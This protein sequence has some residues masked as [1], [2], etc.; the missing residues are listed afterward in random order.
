MAEME[1]ALLFVRINDLEKVGDILQRMDKE[2]VDSKTRIWDDAVDSVLMC[3]MEFSTDVFLLDGVFV[4]IVELEELRQGVTI[5]TDITFQKTWTKLI[6]SSMSTRSKFGL[7]YGDTF[8]SDEVFDLSAPSIFDSCLKDAIEKP[9]YDGFVKAG[10]LHAVPGPITGTFMPPSNKP[11]IDDTQ[12]I[13]GSKSNNSSK[14]NSVSNDFVSCD[15]SDKSSDS[16]TT[17][18]ASCVSSVQTSSSKT[19]EPLA[20]ASSSVDLKTLHKTDEHR[21]PPCKC[22]SYCDFYENQLRLNNAPVWKNVENIPSFVPRPAYVPAGHICIGD[23]RTMVDLNNLQGFPL[24]DPQGRPKSDNPHTN[25]DLGIVDSGCSRSMTGGWS[26][27]GIKGTIRTSN[28]NFENVYYVEELQN[29][30]LFSVSQICDTKNKVLFTDK[31]CL[32][33]SK[34]FQLPDSSQVVLRVPRRHNLYC[35]NLTDIHSE[36]E[37]KCLLAKASLDDVHKNGIGRMAMSPRF[38]LLLPQ[39]EGTS[40]YAEEL[41]RLQGQAYEANSAAK[42]T[43]KTA[44][45]VPAGSGVPATSIPAGS[46]NQATGGS[47]VPSTP[48]SSVVEPVH[49]Y[50]PLPPGHSLGSRCVEACRFARRG[51]IAIGTKMDSMNKRDARGIVGFMVYQMDVKECF[52]YGERILMKES[53]LLNEK[54][55]TIRLPKML[56]RLWEIASCMVCLFKLNHGGLV[57]CSFCR[58]QVHTLDFPIE[59]KERRSLMYSDSD[60]GLGFQ[61]VI[62]ISTQLVGAICWV[63]MYHGNAQKAKQ[64]WQ[65][66]PLIAEYV[67]AAHCVV[68]WG[69]YYGFKINARYGFNFMG[70]TNDPV[71]AIVTEPSLSMIHFNNRLNSGVY[72]DSLR[73]SEV[74]FHQ[75]VLVG[76]PL[77]GDSLQIT[78]INMRRG[79]L[80]FHDDRGEWKSGEAAPP[81][82]PDWTMQLLQKTCAPNCFPHDHG[83][84]SPRPTPTTPAAQLNEPVSKP[85]RPIP[86]SPSAQVNQQDPS[87]DPHVMQLHLKV[88]TSGGAEDLLNLTALYTLVSAHGKK[89]ESLESALQAHKLLFKDVLGK[90]ED[91]EQ[92]VDSLIKLAMAAATAADTSSVPADATKATEFPLCFIHS[93]IH[94]F[95]EMAVPSGT[96]S[97][98]RLMGHVHANQGLTADLLGLDVTE[99]NFTERMVALIA[100]RRRKNACDLQA[101]NLRRSLKRSGADVEQPESKKSK[102]FAA[103]QTPIPAA[104]HQSSAGVTTNVHQSPFVDTPPATPPHSPKASSHPDVTPDTSV[105]PPTP[106]F[107]TPVSRSSGPRTRSHSSAA[108]IKTYSTRRKSLATMKMSSSEV[109]LTAPDK[110]FIQVLSNDDSDDS[111]DDSDPLF[112]HVFAAWEVVP[113]GLGDVNALYFT[114]QSSK[115]FTHLREILHLLDQQDMSKFGMIKGVG[116]RS[117]G[118]HHI[119]LSA[120][121]MKM[122][123]KH[124]L[125]VEIDGIGND[126][127]YAVQLIQFIKNQLASSVPSA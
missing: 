92:D 104:T 98:S 60:Y 6:H 123:L 50:T 121:L 117:L 76:P 9:L 63:E 1:M 61:S 22:H 84:T 113:T 106:S 110:S 19:N 108:G 105:D 13:Y 67:P 122:M 100:E 10:G 16:E 20:S 90:L 51:K 93:M 8:G 40:D 28:F 25:K 55:L 46:I 65:L 86:T 52:L 112:W 85:P 124:K 109:D 11:D 18:F 14:T 31:E 80:Q 44:D 26:F 3:L 87:S 118:L 73:S 5:G 32:V 82:P 74:R 38:I 48:S 41:A 111:D 57:E 99:E 36:R 53:M 21:N 42:D 15:N 78:E 7:G 64:S 91:E 95:I 125:E 29:F 17:D 72:W 56:Y 107:A 81:K 97:D 39:V 49:A 34:E 59:C 54:G 45:T 79:K 24:I 35:F 83:S 37:I 27:T 120:L 75:A 103:P 30:N 114:D 33:L 47:A 127:T 70:N 89:I 71:F 102:S 23:P 126:M 2:K 101:Q 77:M 4:A 115:Y 12:F 119:P 88:Q 66:L 43:W 96:A 68:V 94:L 116:F 58:H 62:G 69:V